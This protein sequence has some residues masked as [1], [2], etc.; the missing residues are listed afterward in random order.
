MATT[1]K[2]NDLKTFLLPLMMEGETTD[3][4]CLLSQSQVVEV[5]PDKPVFRIPGCPRYVKGLVVYSGTT[6]P[7]IDLDVLC[8][9]GAKDDEQYRQMVVV[10]TGIQD[11][12]TG[13]FIKI[14]IA[15][16]T[17][18]LIE[19]IASSTLAMLKAEQD[20]PTNLQITDLLHGLFKTGDKYLVLFD[21]NKIAIG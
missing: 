9:A 4:F 3:L 10:R 20:V 14:V 6:L 12:E 7:V 15:M 18:V 8:G 11:Q 16:R 1:Q 5:L 13:E 17:R 2:Q 19:R 21:F